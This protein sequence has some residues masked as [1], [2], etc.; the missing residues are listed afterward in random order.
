MG[1]FSLQPLVLVVSQQVGRSLL[2]RLLRRQGIG[3][4]IRSLTVQC[5]RHRKLCG[6]FL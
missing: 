5:H 3:M 6:A 2:T 4:G 1:A